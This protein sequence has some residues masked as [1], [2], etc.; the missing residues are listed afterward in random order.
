MKKEPLD[1]IAIILV[2]IG[3]LNLGLVGLLNTDV[4]NLILGSIPVLV[5][6]LNILIGLAALY[7]IYFVTKK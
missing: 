5:T 6:I 2:V 1:W 4:I 7:M 3:G